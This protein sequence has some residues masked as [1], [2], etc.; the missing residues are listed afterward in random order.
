MTGHTGA[1]N[2]LTFSADGTLL[3]SAGDDGTVRLWDPST[4]NPVGNPLAG[5]T[6][7]M[8][9]VHVQPGG[10]L[11]ASAGA[12]GTVWLWDVF[13]NTKACALA[14]PYVTLGEIERYLPSEPTSAQLFDATNQFGQPSPAARTC[15]LTGLAGAPGTTR[16]CDPLLRRQPLFP[17]EL[18][19]RTGRG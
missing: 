4:G 15:I 17:A 7:P 9:A 10:K 14:T 16:T 18:R 6:G 11:L 1:V 12:E 8:Q 5:Q 13:E 3:A 19:G 2:A